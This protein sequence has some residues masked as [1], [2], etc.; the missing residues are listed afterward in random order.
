MACGVPDA[1]VASAG[2]CSALG[3][4]GLP[5]CWEYW[6]WPPTPADTCPGVP[7]DPTHHVSSPSTAGAH[8]PLSGEFAGCGDRCWRQIL[9]GPPALPFA[10]RLLREAAHPACP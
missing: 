10:V 6:E 9:G 7:G 5:S 8:W 1:S 2:P 4:P 3:I